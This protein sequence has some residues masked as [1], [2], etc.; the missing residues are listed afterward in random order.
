MTANRQEAAT[1]PDPPNGPLNPAKLQAEN[2][3]LKRQVEE[4][5]Q[6]IDSPLYEPFFD[7]VR[8]EAAH[9][10]HHRAADDEVKTPMEWNGLIAF[11]SSKAYMA[12]NAGDREKALHHTI[13]SCAALFHWHQHIA[14]QLP[15]DD[16]HE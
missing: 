4:L 11:L 8:N 14:S 13:S 10:A 15:P 1:K 12:H 7:A 5:R 16:C 3:T 6:I 2:I 9:Q